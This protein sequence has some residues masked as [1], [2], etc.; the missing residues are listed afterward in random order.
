MLKPLKR[1]FP[2]CKRK[3]YDQ[4]YTR[5]GC[6]VWIRGTLRGKRVYA[7]AS[8]YLP[9]PECRDM[10]KGRGLALLWEKVGELVRPEAYTAI[11]P[12]SPESGEVARNG[13]VE[14]DRP[15]VAMAVAAYLK[16]AK[17][18]GVRGVTLE[19]KRL[20]F[21]KRLLS[22]CAEK[23]V[24]FVSELD[25]TTTQEWR[26]TW[27]VSARVTDKRQKE[28]IGFFWFCERAGWFLPNYAANL[29]TGLGKIEVKVTQTA[30]FEPGEYK[31]IID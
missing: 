16:A 12:P 2:P 17:D 25:L 30:I 3:E 21:E 4:G 28:V 9:E 13:T 31:A 20:V 14:A 10:E 22:F 23:G 8:K 1:H 7:S 15:T 27:G 19:K 26:G 11:V 6:P 24:R 29:T 5:C 18:R